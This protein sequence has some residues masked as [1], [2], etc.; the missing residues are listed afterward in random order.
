MPSLHI[1]EE[2]FDVLAEE[3]GYNGAKEKVKTLVNNHAEALQDN[4]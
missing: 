2:A 4:E 3:Y 1:S